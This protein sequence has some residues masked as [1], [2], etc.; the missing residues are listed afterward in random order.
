MKGL[1]VYWGLRALGPSLF[2]VLGPL[3]HL[4]LKTKKEGLWAFLALF[5]LA[6]NFPDSGSKKAPSIKKSTWK[7]HAVL[8]FLGK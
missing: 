3:W 4:L 1:R 5:W 8:F 2:K 7:L 6:P